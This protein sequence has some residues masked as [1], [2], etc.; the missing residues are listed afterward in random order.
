M[1]RGAGEKTATAPPDVP[2]GIL[3]FCTGGAGGA[4][5]TGDGGTGAGG[6]GAGGSATVDGMGRSYFSDC[7]S[8][9]ADDTDGAD[10]VHIARPGALCAFTAAFVTDDWSSTGTVHVAADDVVPVP[11]IVVDFNNTARAIGVVVVQSTGTVRGAATAAG[12]GF[13]SGFGCNAGADCSAKATTSGL[14]T[15]DEGRGTTGA[16]VAVGIGFV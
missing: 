5:G 3:F 15:S 12:P 13:C 11:V 8:A 9:A 4:G 16:P 14:V 7:N 2:V 10:G 6:T 1:A